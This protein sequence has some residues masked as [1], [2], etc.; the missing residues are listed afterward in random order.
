MQILTLDFGSQTHDLF[1]GLPRHYFR[2]IQCLQCQTWESMRKKSG[3]D[4]DAPTRVL[5]S[6]SHLKSELV[7]SS[8]GPAGPSR[9]QLS[10]VAATFSSHKYQFNN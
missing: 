9:G 1:V 4:E 8:A 5:V 2:N 6:R 7:S 3:L 10:S